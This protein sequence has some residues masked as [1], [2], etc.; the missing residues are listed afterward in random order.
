MSKLE[1]L[2]W[3]IVGGVLGFLA[4]LLCYSYT[5]EASERLVCFGDSV[6]LG[7]GVT[8]EQSFCAQVGKAIRAK[9]IV[10]S[11]IGGNNTRQALERFSKDV[12]QH[13]PSLVTLMF[14]LNDSFIEEGAAGPR[15][16]LK[17][18]ESNMAY[19]ITQLKR[20]GARVVLMTSNSTAN[21]W[22]NNDLRPY[23]EV[24]RKLAARHRVPFV[25][26]YTYTAELQV[27]GVELY[28]DRVHPNSFV[29]EELAGMILK[30]V[31][32]RS[33]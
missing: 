33:K 5:A 19:F 9:T 11:G 16:S 2:F 18:Y 30:V 12:L 29:H 32:G 28:T 31:R 6:T 20:R 27:E 22:E 17:E 24:V 3:A 4:A 14:G 10:N 26:L 21:A 7:R 23:V 8:Q 1:N 15:I 13:R 25:D